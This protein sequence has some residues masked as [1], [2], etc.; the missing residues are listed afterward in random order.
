MAALQ[1]AMASQ[2]LASHESEAIVLEQTAAQKNDEDRVNSTLLAVP[3]KVESMYRSY[4]GARD[5]ILRYASRIVSHCTKPLQDP[6]EPY[7]RLHRFLALPSFCILD[8]SPC[9]KR[10]WRCFDQPSS[11]TAASNP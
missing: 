5:K 9:F 1:M 10:M 11:C 4:E 6:L 2:V 8:M 3:D 7:H